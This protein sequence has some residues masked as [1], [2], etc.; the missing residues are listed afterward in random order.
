MHPPD[1]DGV[2]STDVKPLPRFQGLGHGSELKL[3]LLDRLF[4][5]TECRGA[6]A[7]P[8]VGNAASVRMQEK[9]G[10]VRVAEG[11]FRFRRDMGVPTS[12]VR[13]Y[14]YLVRRSDWARRKASEAA[15][16]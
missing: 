4:S 16:R 12:P 3:A 15:G 5:T 2:A 11:V 8:N 1:G 10:G 9:V 14:V 13:H 7:T 6:R